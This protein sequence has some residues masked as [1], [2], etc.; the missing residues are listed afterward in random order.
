MRR[1]MNLVSLVLAALSL[2]PEGYFFW[3]TYEPARQ[4]INEHHEIRLLSPTK[5]ICRAHR[6]IAK[7]QPSS[8]DE[9]VTLFSVL[10][11]DPN[12]P[13]FYPPDACLY[14]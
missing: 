6:K 2:G 12:E 1:W 7:L 9:A 8:P 14:P 3:N 13:P 4:Y 5:L 10:R 11:L